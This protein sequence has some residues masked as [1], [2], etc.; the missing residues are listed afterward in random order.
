MADSLSNFT[1]HVKDWNRP[2][3]GYIGTCKRHPLSSLGNIQ[4]AMEQSNSRNLANLEMET[5]DELENVLNHEELLWRQNARCDWLQ[6]GD[7]NTKFFHSRTMQRRKFNRILALRIRNDEWCSEQSILNEEA[8]NYFEKLYGENPNPMPDIPSNIFPSLK[9]QDIDFLKK[10]MVNEEIKKTLFDMDPLKAPGSDGYHALFFQ[11][12]WD[13]IGGAV[14]E[15]VQGI[16]AGKRIEGELNNTLIVLIPKKDSPEDFSQFRPISLCSVIYKL[17]MKVIANR[18]KVVFPNFISP[19]QAGFIAR[20]NISDNV[21]IAQEVIHS[22]CSRKAGKN[23]MAIKLDLEKAYDRV[24]WKFIEVSFVAAGIPEGL[25]KVIINTIS[26][27][28]MQILWNGVPSRS[29]KPV[30]GIRQGCPLSPYLFVLC[31]EWLGHFISS[32]MK[33]GRW[34]PI[35]LS[36]SGPALSHIFFADDLV[37]FSKVE[38]N[39]THLLKD[40]LRCFCDLSDHK[41]SARKS[42]MFFSKGVDTSLSDQISQ[43][44]SFQKVRNLG[45]YLGVLLHNRVTR[46]TLKFVIDKVKSKLQN[47]DARKLSLAGRVTL[48]QSVLLAIPSYFMQTMAIPK[49]VCDEIERI[50]RQF[51]WGRSVG[52]PKLALVGWE[53]ICQPRS[54][55]GLELR[56]LQDHNNSFI[57]KIGFNLTSQKDALWVRFL[58]SKYGWKSQLLESI[59]KSN[60]SHLWKSL[61]KVWPLLRENLM[62]SV[63]DGAKICGWKDN[64]IPDAGPL[65]SYVFAL[66]RINLDST[67]K[68][69]VLPDGSWNIDMLRIWL[70]DAMIKRI[71]SIPPPHPAGGKDR[72]IWA[73][74]GSGSFSIRSAYW[75]SK[76]SSWRPRNDIWKSIWRYQGPHRVRL[77]LWIV[78][79]Q[80]L[81]TNS[82][83]TRRGIGQSNACPRCGHACEDIMHVLRDCTTAKEA[84]ILVVP[85]EKHSRFFSEPLQSWLTSNLCCHL[86]LQD[87]ET[88]WSCL[89][90]IIAWRIWKNRNLSIFQN[91]DWTPIELIKSSLSWAQSFET[92]NTDS[93]ATVTYSRNLQHCSDNWVHLSSDRAVVRISGN[94]SAR[95][96]VRDQNGNWILG[97]TH[98][99][100]RCSSLEVELWGVLDG[101]LILLNKGYKKVKIQTDNLE[102]VR[103]LSM[104]DIVDSGTTILRRIKRL[105]HSEGQWEIKHVPRERNIIADQMAKIGLSWQTS[106]R[107][108][109]VPPNAVA[110]ALQQDKIFCYKQ[111]V[112]DIVQGALFPEVGLHDRVG[113]AGGAG[114]LVIV[115]DLDMFSYSES[116]LLPFQVKCHVGYVP[117]G[118][119]VVGLS[120]LSRVADIFA[121]RLQDPQCLAD[122]VCSAL[123]L[124]INPAGVAMILQCWHIHFPNLESVF[125]DAKHQGWIKVLVSSGSG[126]FEN[127]NADAWCDFLGLLKF[128]VAKGSSE[129]IAPNPRM[130]AAVASI[131][132]SLGE[133][134]SRKELLETPSHFVRW[135][136]NFQNTE[137]EMKFNGFTCGIKDVLKPNGECSHNH[138]QLHTVLSLSFWSQCEHHLLPFHG[139]VHIGYLCPEGFNPIEKSLLQSVVH[140]YGFKLQVQERLTR[141]IAETVS[142]ILGVRYHGSSG[143]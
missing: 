23:W 143:G 53:S 105:L 113:H 80:R 15:W 131:L 51:I 98:F 65:L 74:S 121:K 103:V 115:R 93:K 59:L 68:D 139:A 99:L 88:T 72:I 60:C 111:K 96:V 134:P 92:L 117:S 2:I 9:E 41:I 73:S 141:Q 62:W 7:R 38:M 142:S 21:I 26:S 40:I 58:R 107:I 54:C 33:I 71:V 67:L 11:S 50:A 118:E 94:A 64:W 138:Q 109:E 137:L 91:I 30:R 28:T 56:H 82:E 140:F 124:G 127:E 128:R 48:A 24:S 37:I 87:K 69:W 116:C 81:L 70:P 6:F 119:Q 4:K 76:E 63:G 122:E 66:E 112:K 47:W 114:G 126:V 77:F 18:F 45:N 110:M 34:H 106:L 101:V 12:Q 86:K 29:F 19:E 39:Q 44:F 85:L 55:G 1:Y 132:G 13:L 97:F 20:R 79:N 35:R 14:C 100:G 75:A 46:S 27:S 129:S 57:M 16:F 95:G 22:M 25:R 32:E 120:K 84:W 31:M 133:D 90:G 136:M 3:Y 89:F 130:V 8:V 123:H 108:F 36:R 83:R 104:E 52:N 102:V 49:G 78:A 17:V 42:K 43:L 61:S 10:P 135:L 5:R 125:H